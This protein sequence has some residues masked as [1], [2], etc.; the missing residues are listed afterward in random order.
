MCQLMCLSRKMLLATY[1]KALTYRRTWDS[2]SRLN[3]EVGEWPTCWEVKKC[4]RTCKEADSTQLSRQTVPTPSTRS[5]RQEAD[6]TQL[7][8]QTVGRR[9]T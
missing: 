4:P 3:K 9:S 2:P 8:C 1:C 6:S 7:S 5:H